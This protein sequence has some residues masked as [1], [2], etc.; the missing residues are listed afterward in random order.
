MIQ[1]GVMRQWAVLL[2]VAGMVSVPCGWAAETTEAERFSSWTVQCQTGGPDSTSEA[3][4]V[5]A[6]RQ[7][8]SQQNEAGE[9]IPVLSILI[10]LERDATGALQG[11]AVIT[12]PLSVR[13]KPGAMLRIESLEM[14]ADYVTCTQGGCVARATFDPTVIRSLLSYDTAS[15]SFVSMR[16][17]V[18]TAP[19]STEG[20]DTAWR[21]I[22]TLIEA[23]S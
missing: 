8:L 5:C 20:F 23:G 6:M 15:V 10:G 16:R 12:T 4:R 1:Q 14:P 21:R 3:T 2:G 11:S 13:L 19:L 22:D 17:G 9:R 7:T 18:L